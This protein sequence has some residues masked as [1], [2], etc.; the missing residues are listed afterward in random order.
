MLFFGANLT[1]RKP[2][3]SRPRDHG[4]LTNNG[5]S[6]MTFFARLI[7]K[8]LNT[9]RYRDDFGPSSFERARERG[10]DSLGFYFWALSQ[11]IFGI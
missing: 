7:R 11:S 9:P 1:Q 4:P 8:R 3:E 10:G 2:P 6:A 5:R